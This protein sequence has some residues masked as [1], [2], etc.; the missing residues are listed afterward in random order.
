MR[1][2]KFKFDYSLGYSQRKKLAE[3]YQTE[4]EEEL[5]KIW[6]YVLAAYEKENKLSS[7]KDKS[8]SGNHYRVLC[9]QQ[10][11]IRSYV[12]TRNGNITETN[13]ENINYINQQIEAYE[14]LK[15]VKEIRKKLEI[16]SSNAVIPAS[17]IKEI[18]GDISE[19]RQAL[20]EKPVYI[21]SHIR[22]RYDL[23]KNIELDYAN[24]AHMR[25]IL[26]NFSVLEKYVMKNNLCVLQSVY[27]D[28]K[29]V[30][31]RVKL[32]ERQAETL[33]LYMSGQSITGRSR[34]LESVVTK[35]Q[36]ELLGGVKDE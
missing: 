6:E 25:A 4:D 29:R 12:D 32:T 34:E 19:C 13:Y 23:F 15:Q 24:R 28:V 27:M 7:T 18:N 1:S 33:E 21:T 11:G 5:I 26:G 36:K 16:A 35:Y 20:I 14:D 9:D 30:S 22:Q 2:H 17:V 8:F 10:R 3:A 31:E